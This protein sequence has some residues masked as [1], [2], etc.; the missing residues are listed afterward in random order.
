MIAKEHRE[1]NDNRQWIMQR[2][3]WDGALEKL[4]SLLDLVKEDNS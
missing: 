2:Y 4:P 1:S 3:S